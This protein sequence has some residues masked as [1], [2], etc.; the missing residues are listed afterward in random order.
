MILYLSTDDGS[1]TIIAKKDFFKHTDLGKTIINKLITQTDYSSIDNL[2]FVNNVENT[3]FNPLDEVKSTT[4]YK[5]P[6]TIKTH[7]FNNLTT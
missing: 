6:E 3:F 5:I 2:I 7:I 1:Y 4:N